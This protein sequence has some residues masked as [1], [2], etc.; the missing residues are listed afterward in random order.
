ML[1]HFLKE[2]LRLE[3]QSFKIESMTELKTKPIKPRAKK[4]PSSRGVQGVKGG[5]GVK[6][7]QVEV[8]SARG[9]M[10]ASSFGQTQYFLGVARKNSPTVQKGLQSL[11]GIGPSV[12]KTVCHALSRNPDAP[13]SR[14][15]RDEHRRLEQYV[16][17]HRVTESERRR[18]EHEIM[19]RHR[20]RGTTRGIRRRL[21]LPVRGQ[22]TKSNAKT[23]KRLNRS[24]GSVS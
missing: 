2:D 5:Q 16:S 19:A 22:R 13:F 4:T 9:K 14:R 23:A 3:F 7:S 24:R 10:D 21:G 1:E 17:D 18:Q 12:A 8:N 11:Y 20:S 15:S 6:G